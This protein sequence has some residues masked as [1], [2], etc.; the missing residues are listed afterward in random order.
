[1]LNRR[2]ISLALGMALAVMLTAGAL[3]AS[4]ATSNTNADGQLIVEATANVETAAAQNIEQRY[5]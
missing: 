4:T 2:Q 1:M 3:I 5:D